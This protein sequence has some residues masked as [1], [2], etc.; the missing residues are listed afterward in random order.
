MKVIVWIIKLPFLFVK[1]LWC[2][3]KWA[4]KHLFALLFGWI[5]D[6][7]ERMSGE[8]FEEYVKEIL[9]RNGYKKV[10]L[11]KHSGD[12]GIDIL[13][14][15]RGESYAIQCKFYSRPVGVAAV[16]QA[17]AGCCY[18]DCDY[19]VVVTNQHFTSQAKKLAMN[20][21][22]ELWDGERLDKMK[23]KANLHAIFHQRKSHNVIEDMYGDIIR[24]LL[25]ENYASCELLKN[26]FCYSEEK[27]YYILEDFEFYDLVSK[28]DENQRREICFITYQEAIDKL[29]Q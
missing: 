4:F 24:L 3:I 23:R 21:G 20:N 5:P 29:S 16:Q 13:A 15:Y 17:Y 28:E 7:N 6:L 2:P 9:K 25:K 27:A 14:E 18:Y 11:T 26:N 10:Q 1:C 22:V 19:P 12:Y 8:D